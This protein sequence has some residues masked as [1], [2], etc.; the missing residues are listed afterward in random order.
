MSFTINPRPPTPEENAR[1]WWKKLT[2]FVGLYLISII[3][4]G[5]FVYGMR[6]ILGM[7]G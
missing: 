3:A 5:G 6:I 4:V 2:W 7:H 1:P